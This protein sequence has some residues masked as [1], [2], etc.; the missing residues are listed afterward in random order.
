MKVK[1]VILTKE[2]SKRNRRCKKLLKRNLHENRHLY[3]SANVV[4]SNCSWMILY[5]SL[6]G[7]IC[8]NVSFDGKTLN[9]YD[10][11]H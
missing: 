10:F 1:M 2:K 4:L 9:T 8:K 6:E 7:A 5:K 3:Y 11:N